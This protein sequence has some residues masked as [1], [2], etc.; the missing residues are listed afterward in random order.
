M[1][2]TYP[3]RGGIS[4]YTTLLARGMASHHEVRVFS[5]RRQYPSFLFPGSTQYDRSQR[6]L[7]VPA[8]HLL[9][10]VGPL[11]WLRTARAIESFR[12][13]LTIIQWWQPFFGLAVGRVCTMLRRW[14]R[15]GVLFLC[16]NVVPHERSVIDRWLS[17]HAL[18][19]GDMFVVHSREDLANLLG[20]VPHAAA[21][22]HPHPT[23]QVF[24]TLSK[25]FAGEERAPGDRR[26][27]FFGYV[28]EYK[29]LRYLLRAM[30][31]IRRELDVKL[32]VVG[33]FYEDVA[34]YRRLISELGIS[35]AVELVDRYVANEEVGR[36][37][38]AADLVVLPYVT[39]TQSGI[40]QIAYSFGVPV[41]TTSVGGLPE[42][43][44]DGKTG[45]L[46]PPS[47]SWA[48]ARAVLT[49][50][51][52]RE[53]WDFPSAIARYVRRFSWEA[54]VATIEQLYRSAAPRG[55]P[56]VSRRRWQ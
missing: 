3:Y 41:V 9:D 13:D 16:H 29:G 7:E 35:H 45:Y 32:L 44:E 36:Y 40:I 26:I 20:L 54:M 38:S 18:S 24:R 47:D 33:E 22:V 14:C 2:L 42:V 50:Y 37:F 34:S 17:R 55:H 6:R 25:G 43:V 48:I 21:V 31:E 5:Y 53:Q 28:R 56:P 30:P 10:S 8:T 15:C 39:A 51:R 11:S 19:K 49:Y 52:Q 27:L 23:Y 46:V 1:G 12:P 4:H